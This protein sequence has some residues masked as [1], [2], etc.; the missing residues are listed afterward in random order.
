MGKSR[1]MVPKKKRILVL[2]GGFAGVYTAL[3]L[4]KTFA[5]DDSIQGTLVSDENFLLFTPMLPEVASSSIEAKH[6]ISPVRAFF[7]KVQFHNSEACA[8]DLGKRRLVV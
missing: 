4:E 8:I 6:I 3:H 2:G 5:G 7:H 1:L